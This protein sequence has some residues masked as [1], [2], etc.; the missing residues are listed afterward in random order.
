[1]HPRKTR[2]PQPGSAPVSAPCQPLLFAHPT[3][4]LLRVATAARAQPTRFARRRWRRP[5]RPQFDSVAG[6]ID[7]AHALVSPPT[8]LPRRRLWC[9][10]HPRAP[11]FPSHHPTCPHF[12]PKSARAGGGSVVC[13]PRPC[14]PS[15]LGPP[16]AVPG[17]PP[18]VSGGGCRDCEGRR[19]CGRGRVLL[20]SLPPPS[21]L[22]LPVASR[23]ASTPPRSS[24][25]ARAAIPC[26]EAP[27]W[28]RW[29]HTVV[30]WQSLPRPM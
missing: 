22:L 16:R 27:R 24:F 30:A 14:P 10:F 15:R 11:L 3:T 29:L 13:R 26:A 8:P 28:R 21:L 6:R 23:P 19:G 7:R 4:S 25:L 2:L 5:C 9:L 12:Y 1:M 17:R 20:A 18:P